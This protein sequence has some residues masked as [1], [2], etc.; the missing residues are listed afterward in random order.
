MNNWLTKSPLT[1]VMFVV[2]VVVAELTLHYRK[3]CSQR[4]I[5]LWLLSSV[6]PHDIIAGEELTCPYL[7]LC[8]LLKD[9]AERKYIN[10]SSMMAA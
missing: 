7:T 4:T 5:K 1:A 10:C 3:F 6:L 2:I 9:A 8:A